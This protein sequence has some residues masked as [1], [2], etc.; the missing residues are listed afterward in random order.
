MSNSKSNRQKRRNKSKVSNQVLINFDHRLC[1]SSGRFDPNSAAELVI[2][3]IKR[4]NSIMDLYKNHAGIG[5][6]KRL[7][8]EILSHV[9]FSVMMELGDI[10]AL[11]EAFERSEKTKPYAFNTIDQHLASSKKIINKI[12]MDLAEDVA[13]Q[14]GNENICGSIDTAKTDLI[15]I[16]ILF[17]EL[18]EA[19]KTPSIN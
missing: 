2:F 7:D 8:K 5:D 9:L 12:I 13:N 6:I 4:T 1:L 10:S 16:G 3:I 15:N 11:M 18:C 17:R 14:D 19:I